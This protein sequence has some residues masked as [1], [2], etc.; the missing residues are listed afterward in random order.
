MNEKPA[1]LF[2]E[3]EIARRVA[4]LG[5][6]VTKDYAGEEVCVVGLMKSCLVFMADLI[7]VIGLPMT[8]HMVRATQSGRG[9]TEI[10]YSAEAPY[11]GR[12]ILLLEEISAHGC[13]GRG[14]G[15]RDDGSRDYFS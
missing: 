7:R 14:R 9:G 4:E 5:A 15:I 2:G 8:C 6:Q 10:A 1:V 12:H 11:E 13:D 3:G